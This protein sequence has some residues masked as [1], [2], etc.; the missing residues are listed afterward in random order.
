MCVCLC[1]CMCVCTCVCMCACVCE[2]VCVCVTLNIYVDVV[3]TNILRARMRPTHP[4]DTID[5]LALSHPFTSHLLRFIIF[6]NFAHCLCV[7]LFI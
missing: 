5:F 1:A 7:K 3:S 2:N 4:I 6:P